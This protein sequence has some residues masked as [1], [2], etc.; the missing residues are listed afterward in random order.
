MHPVFIRLPLNY[1][2][3]ALSQA[4]KLRIVIAETLPAPKQ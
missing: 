1:A 2:P 3:E 4:V